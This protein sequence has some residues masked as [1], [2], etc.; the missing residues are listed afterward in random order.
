MSGVFIGAV[1]TG[2]GVFD[3]LF[4]PRE[5]PVASIEVR[6]M[7]GYPV[8]EGLWELFH[9]LWHNVPVDE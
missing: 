9:Y 1:A 6:Y 2:A 8:L 4:P 7:P 5:I 3:T